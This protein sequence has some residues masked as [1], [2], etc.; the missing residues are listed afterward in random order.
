V[1]SPIK[2]FGKIPNRKC[3]RSW[4]DLDAG[5]WMYWRG[6]EIPTPYILAWGLFTFFR[7]VREVD[8]VRL[9][10][11]VKRVQSDWRATVALGCPI[12]EK[13]I[14]QSCEQIYKY[15][16]CNLEAE[17]YIY[18]ICYYERKTFIFYLMYNVMWLKAK[19]GQKVHFAKFCNIFIVLIIIIN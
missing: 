13:V 9:S 6:M 3:K 1:R 7:V 17:N 14:A 5:I 4:S 10:P 16:S 8:L 15:F 2:L 11:R 18:I 19:Y 12:C